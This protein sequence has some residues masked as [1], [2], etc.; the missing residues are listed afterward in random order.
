MNLLFALLPY[1]IFARAIRQRC[2]L[3]I[4]SRIVAGLGGE[5][6]LWYFLRW[7]DTR[8]AGFVE[9]SLEELAD[10]I[11]CGQSTIYQWLRVGESKKVFRCWRVERGNLRV[12]LGGLLPISEA[13]GLD[14][15]DSGLP[16]W[17]ATAKINIFEIQSLA[18][19]RAAASA[20]TA[21]RMQ[22][23]SRYAAWKKLPRQA[24]KTYRLPRPGQILDAKSFSLSHNSANQGSVKCLL[25]VGKHR[26]FVS[27]G[28][29]PY[30]VSL[31]SIQHERG[32]ECDRTI[33]RHLNLLEIDRRQLCQAKAE[34]GQA[35]RAIDWDAP[36]AALSEEIYLKSNGREYTLTEPSGRI[37]KPHSFKLKRDRLFRYGE[38]DWIYRCNIYREEFDLCSMA[39]RRREYRQYMDSRQ[40]GS[41]LQKSG[42]PGGVTG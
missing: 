36:Q 14:P 28:F 16:P 5:A 18:A 8:G 4:H 34:Y 7:L 29:I 23:L 40:R 11:G 37:G 31:S 35:A 1:K 12:A 21:Q 15:D 30:G 10:W 39:A 32:Y 25:H 27:K 19:L 13:L 41:V 26:V 9:I 6:R 22:Q 33:S 2:T 20:A 17:G 3:R 42:A 38:R 24:R